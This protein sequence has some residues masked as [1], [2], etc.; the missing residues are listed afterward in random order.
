M[1]EIREGYERD[2]YRKG[3]GRTGMRREMTAEEA[4]DCGYEDGYEAAMEEME[5]K[6]G[7]RMG[8]RTRMY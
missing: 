2:G 4:Y 1:W 6:T 5:G 7:H 8:Q 3:R